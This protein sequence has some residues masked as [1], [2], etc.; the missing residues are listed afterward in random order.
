MGEGAGGGWTGGYR[1]AVVF[2]RPSGLGG[3]LFEP[4]GRCGYGFWPVKEERRGL[5]RVRIDALT[6][7][8]APPGRVP[9][10]T[11]PQDT[12]RIGRPYPRPV[13]RYRGMGNRGGTP[14]TSLR[15]WRPRTPQA[16]RLSSTRLAPHRD[17]RA[18][19]QITASL[20]SFPH[21]QSQRPGL[22]WPHY[23]Q[24]YHSRIARGGDK[25]PK[26]APGGR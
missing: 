9:Q 11:D 24:P 14:A 12:G 20:A 18:P 15:P 3:G 19:G 13:A 2:P 10:R 8:P 7:P 22:L 21:G 16:P 4:L 1:S 5:C 26:A 23:I 17:G 6:P 25:P